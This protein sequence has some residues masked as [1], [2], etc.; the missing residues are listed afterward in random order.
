MYAVHLSVL[1]LLIGGLVGSI[2]GFEGFV[3]IPEGDTVNTIQLRNSNQKKVLDFSIRCDDFEVQ[4]YDTGAPKLFR[5]SLKILENDQVVAKKDIIV[6]DPLTYKGI[7]IYQSSYGALSAKGATLN[8][9]SPDT[10]LVYTAE[11]G[12]G[13][14]VEVPEAGGKFV[15]T[16][17]RNSYPFRGRNI[18]EVFIGTIT[19]RNGKTSEVVMPLRFPDFDRMRN[20]NWMISA[21]N[22]TYWYYTGLQVSKDPSV[23][24]VYSGFIIMI[25]GCYITF[26][27]SHQRAY[28]EVVGKKNHTRIRVSGTANKNKLGMH[29]KVNFVA[30]KLEGLGK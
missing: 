27:M 17:Y 20:G 26:F 18:G 2:F 21:T 3:N 24:I 25:L 13:A 22:P 4:F 5:S 15:L 28:V 29:R 9:K 16:D 19:P 14:V 6:N 7:S 8:F 1:I 23:W 11:A 30:Q 12:M 10:G